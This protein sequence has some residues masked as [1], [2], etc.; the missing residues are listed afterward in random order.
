[1]STNLCTVPG[2]VGIL[3]QASTESFRV[4]HLTTIVI[5]RV[6][7]KLRLDIKREPG[8]PTIQDKDP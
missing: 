6:S 4:H 7:Q 8:A 2:T 1:M 5:V 3:T